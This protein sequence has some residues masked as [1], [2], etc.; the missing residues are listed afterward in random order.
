MPPPIA[1]AIKIQHDEG[2]SRLSL[3]LNLAAYHLVEPKPKTCSFK[4]ILH[5]PI[6]FEKMHISYDEWQSA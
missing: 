5:Q 6:Y 2:N 1:K 3:R 4:E